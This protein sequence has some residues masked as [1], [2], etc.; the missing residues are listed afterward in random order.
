MVNHKFENIQRKYKKFGWVNTT[1][2]HLL[3]TVK[4]GIPEFF[5]LIKYKAL[6]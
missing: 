4:Q 3:L 5:S 1:L 6:K 2:C